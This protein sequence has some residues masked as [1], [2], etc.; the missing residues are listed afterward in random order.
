VGVIL[1][2]LAPEEVLRLVGES[3]EKADDP[4]AVLWAIEIKET[5]TARRVSAETRS[6]LKPSRWWYC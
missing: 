3:P 6:A 1:S 2:T 4:Q 5:N